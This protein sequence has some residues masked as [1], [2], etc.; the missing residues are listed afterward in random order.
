MQARAT[1][2]IVIIQSLE[3][4][5]LLSVAA[6][7]LS[8]AFTGTP[9]KIAPGASTTIQAEN[10]DNGGEGIAYHDVD[11]ANLGGRFRA[12]GVDIQPT[13]DAGAGYNVGW[14]RPG[15]WLKYSVD[16]AAA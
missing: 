15:E 9:T 10:F 8:T 4:R 11:A 14:T 6:G 1:Q 7:P 13:T 2:S 16:I 5:R 12:T 3:S